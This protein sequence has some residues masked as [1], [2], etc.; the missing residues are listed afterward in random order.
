MVH[1]LGIVSLPVFTAYLSPEEYGIANVFLSY[2]PVLAAVMSCNLYGTGGRYFFEKD[3]TDYPSYMGSIFLTMGISFFV[4]GCIWMLLAPQ[5]AKWMN[6][7]VYLMKWMLGTALLATV[8]LV[9]TQ[10]MV[11]I[12]K[13][14]QFIVVQVILQYGK[15]GVAVLGMAYLISGRAGASW[16]GQTY[17]GKIIGEFWWALAIGIYA[18][19]SIRK[20]I[21]FKNTSWAHV[22]YAL[23]FG[24]PLL[25]L[26]LSGYLLTSFDQ[27]FINSTVGQEEAGRYAFAYKIGMLYLGL[28]TA[29]INGANQTYYTYMNA[30]ET[31]KVNDQIKSMVKLLVL[32]ACFLMFFAIDIG[33][34]LSS[35]KAFLEALPVT[36][37]IIGSYVFYGI[38]STT[39]RGIYF[40]KRT[41]YL[42]IIMILAGVINIGLNVYFIPEYGYQAAAY[43]TLVSYLLMMLL[44]IA[45]TTYILKLPP[46]PMGEILKY[47]VFWAVVVALQY[48]FGAPEVGLDWRWMLF[49]GGLFVLLAVLLFYNKIGLLLNRPPKS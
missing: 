12:E 13:S 3:K 20:Y 17:L 48:R 9:Y 39:N 16:E 30:D 2:I 26:G 7:P 18:C 33:T 11:S 40:I 45:V 15:F 46:P 24:I 8:M 36:P 37:V 25:P 5:L 4:Q 27:W 23:S 34:L 1:A 44:S 14:K 31:G 41:G 21:S 6:L 32:G 19:W 10:V 47:L 29:L 28:V 38:A 22:R 43:T 49:K 35:D 42:S